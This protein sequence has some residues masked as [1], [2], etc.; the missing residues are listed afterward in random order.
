MTKSLPALSG[1]LSKKGWLDRLAISLALFKDYISIQ[2]GA[3]HLDSSKLA[4]GLM[5]DLLT[6]V[7]PWGPFKT[8]DHEYT[9]HPAID[10]LSLD[11]GVGV[12]VTSSSSLTK[13]TETIEKFHKLS[14]PPTELYILMICGRAKSYSKRSIEKALKNST[15]KFDP[16]R[17]ILT[18][19]DI[20]NFA[21]RKRV[22]QISKAV[23]RL[24]EE[25]SSRALQLLQRFNASADRVLQVMTA[26]EVS[27]AK[28]IE[29]LELDSSTDVDAVYS[30]HSLQPL[31]KPSAYEAIAAAFNVPTE[32]LSGQRDWLADRYG[33]SE[34]RSEGCVSGLIERLLA[35]YKSVRFKIVLPMEPGG[36]EEDINTPVLVFFEADSKYGKVYGHLGIQP[37][38]I[39]HHCKA[40]LYLGTVVRHL[41]LTEGLAVSVSW[42]QWPRD[43]IMATTTDL[44]LAEAVQQEPRV[45]LD[46][47]QLIDYMKGK[48]R[49]AMNPELDADFNESYAPAV[50]KH[51][52][53][54]LEQARRK[55]YIKELISE[56]MSELTLP[57]PQKRVARVFG[58][59]AYAIAKRCRKKVS[60]VDGNGKVTRVSVKAARELMGQTP[61]MGEQGQVVKMVFVDVRA[62]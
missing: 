10:L 32:W 16:D 14:G 20:Y 26:H 58:H 59:E 29:L 38:D 57:P 37:W 15:T 7:G 30:A 62:E 46:E 31:L 28:I 17:N 8:L 41:S 44:L 47:T 56:A 19:P 33:S 61:A 42:W 50:Q 60:F 24:E 51:V 48:W 4:E 18:L 25:M 35:S 6:L 5:E 55:D 1:D 12:Q 2:K 43:R 27:P 13:V 54:C 21:V 36:M 52:L 45:H 34:W 23:Q 40:A 49:F 53:R 9:N 3:V 11:G 22:G 39:D